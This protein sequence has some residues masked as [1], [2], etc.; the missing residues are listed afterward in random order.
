MQ[1]GLVDSRRTSMAKSNRNSWATRG[2]QSN[3][4]LPRRR[5]LVKLRRGGK[6]PHATSVRLLAREVAMVNA[7]VK[8]FEKAAWAAR[9]ET[10]GTLTA[11][12]GDIWLEG[13]VLEASITEILS[14]K[15]PRERERLQSILIGLEVRLVSQLLDR[16]PDLGKAL[17]RVIRLLDNP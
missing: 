8:Q 5:A 7:L 16:L 9:G 11:T 12:L 10:L 4:K 3:P 14:L 2:E 17:R 1:R 6:T 15:L 13:F